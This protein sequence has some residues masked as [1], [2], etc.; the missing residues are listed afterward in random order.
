MANTTNTVLIIEDVLTTRIGWRNLLEGIG[1][2]VLEA[3]D[4]IEGFTVLRKEKVDVVVL[5]LSF[6]TT[7]KR[8]GIRLLSKKSKK[9]SMKDIPVIIVTGIMTKQIVNEQ[10][11]YFTDVKAV[12]EKPIDNKVLVEQIMKILEE[13]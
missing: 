13:S 3:R 9:D 11:K 6:P 7:G 8:G 4:D 5:D 1:F 2:Q 12:F 10:A